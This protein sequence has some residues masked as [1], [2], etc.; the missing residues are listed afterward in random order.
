MEDPGLILGSNSDNF[1][2]IGHI[3]R[4]GDLF[5]GLNSGNC[6]R[7]GHIARKESHLG[8]DAATPLRAALC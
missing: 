3:L 8:K 5:R 7:I 1:L 2:Q 6:W 4:I